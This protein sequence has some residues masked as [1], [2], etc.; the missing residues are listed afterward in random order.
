MYRPHAV[1]RAWIVHGSFR[2]RDEVVAPRSHGHMESM[3]MN[4]V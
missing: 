1:Q 2:H 4:C 3:G